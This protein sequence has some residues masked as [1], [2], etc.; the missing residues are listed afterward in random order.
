MMDINN[1]PIY[2]V[3]G[4]KNSGK[5]TLMTHLVE[6]YTKQGL[7]VGTL[8]HHGHG[9]EPDLVAGTDSERHLEAGAAVTAVKGT[10]SV[11]IVIKDTSAYQIDDLIQMYQVLGIDIL[12]IEGYKQLA[13]PKVVLIKDEADEQLLTELTEVIAVGGFQKPA[14]MADKYV[15]S[16]LEIEA[17][18]PKLAT[19]FD[20]YYNK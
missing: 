7:Q 2:Q 16:L 11:H 18:L 20:R 4:Y 12:L 14:L 15:F 3:V 10:S 8:K 5:T 1:L 17:A 6:Y 19:V 13:Y 9:G